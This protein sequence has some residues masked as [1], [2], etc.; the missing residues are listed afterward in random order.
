MTLIVIRT[1]IMYLFIM[2]AV[3]IMGKRQ[4]GEMQAGDLVVT[5]LISEIA[6]I[7]LQDLSAPL[8]SGITSIF[9]LVV[10]E[11]LIS[12]LCLAS[13]WLRNAVS[14]KA[15]IV[16]ANGTIDQKALKKLRMTVDDLL[17]T[18]RLKN[19][20]DLSNVQYAIVETNGQLSVLLDPG[21]RPATAVEVQAEPPDDGG[22]MQLLI[23]DGKLL[24]KELKKSP[25]S[26][27]ELDKELKK[28]KLRIKDVFILAVN[29]RKQFE[30]VEKEKSA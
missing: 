11:V 5:I 25:L 18:L 7:P 16:I 15:V 2:I 14:G 20:F 24:R 13:V 10:L 22:M 27:E 4:I 21:S 30:I 19:V 17:E 23:S 12:S 8:L 1:V 6:A 3:R 28:R 9:T 29:D 26:R